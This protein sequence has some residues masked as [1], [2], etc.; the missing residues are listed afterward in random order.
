MCEVLDWRTYM[1]GVR[2]RK[3]AWVRSDLSPT[4]SQQVNHDDDQ[5]HHQQKVNQ[6]TADVE[7]NKAQ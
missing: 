2:G 6:P 4:T 5:C 1:N 3:V 7:D